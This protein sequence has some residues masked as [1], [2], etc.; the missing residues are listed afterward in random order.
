MSEEIDLA[1]DEEQK[2]AVLTF[3]NGRKLVL[4]NVTREKAQDFAKRH[5]PEFA[6]RDCILHTAGDISMRSD[7]HG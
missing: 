5:A 1:Y 3:K 6:R 7:D 2:R 4:A